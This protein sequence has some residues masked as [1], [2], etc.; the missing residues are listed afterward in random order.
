MKRCRAGAAALARIAVLLV[1]AGAAA[2][3][4]FG[5]EHDRLSPPASPVISRRARWAMADTAYVPLRKEPRLEA[6]INAHMR[7][8]DIG[9]IA[10]RTAFRE[11]QFGRRSHWYRIRFGEAEGWVHGAQIQRFQLVRQAENAA[12]R[13][14][15]D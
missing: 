7:G 4:G 2:G 3:C 14:L 15:D 6:R 5:E 1:L 8:G 11:T 9:E 12:V 13:W 10:E